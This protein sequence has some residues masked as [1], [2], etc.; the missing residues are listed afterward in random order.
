MGSPVINIVSTYLGLLR[1]ETL[2]LL[3]NVRSTLIIAV[4]HTTTAKVL[5]QSLLSGAVL[6]I[7]TIL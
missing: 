7:Q 6:H 4:T 3:Y 2:F 1:P 5:P